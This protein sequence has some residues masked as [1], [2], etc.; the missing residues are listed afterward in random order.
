[1][2]VRLWEAAGRPDFIAPD[3]S[4]WQPWFYGDLDNL[5]N[6]LLYE[7]YPYRR[8]R[9][10]FLEAMLQR[11]KLPD[12]YD[13]AY[14]ARFWSMFRYTPWSVY[15]EREAGCGRGQI[16]NPRDFTAASGM[17]DKFPRARLLGLGWKEVDKDSSD[18]TRGLGTTAM[19]KLMNLAERGGGDFESPMERTGASGSRP[20]PCLDA[21]IGG[22]RR[23]GPA[24]VSKGH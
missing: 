14:V 13:P 17:R 10:G 18:P 11:G 15:F 6:N 24:A 4:R 8:A 3:G 22:S 1:M 9:A 5:D 2:T 23:S 19:E 7:G 16:A 12:E 21:R 20:R